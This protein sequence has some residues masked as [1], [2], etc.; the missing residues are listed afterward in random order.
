VALT[1]EDVRHVARLAR[2][3]LTDEEIELFTRQLNDILAYVAKLQELDTSGVAPLAQVMPLANVMRDDAVQPGLER[4][5][6]LDN[7]PAR[8]EGSFLVPRVI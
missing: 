1:G 8:E 6:S 4:E 5:L 7:A 2:L 3:S